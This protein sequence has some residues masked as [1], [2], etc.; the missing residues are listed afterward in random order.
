[1][2][3]VALERVV[4]RENV[5]KPMNEHGKSPGMDKVFETHPTLARQGYSLFWEAGFVIIVDQKSGEEEH[6]P[7]SVV[8][9]QRPAKNRQPKIAKAV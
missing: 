8:L 7:G 1:M 4:F 5:N 6:V 3:R 2:S 9:Q